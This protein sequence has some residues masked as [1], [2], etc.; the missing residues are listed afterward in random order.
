MSYENPLRIEPCLVDPLPSAL[1]DLVAEVG[2]AAAALG[3]ALHPRT[4]RS[5]S[6]LVALMNCYYSNLIEG[7]RTRPRDI[8]RALV[9]E[10]DTDP[11]RRDLQLEAISHVRVQSAIESDFL[12]GRMADPTSPP[13]ILKLHQDFYEGAS[14]PMLQLKRADGSTFQMQPG[15]FRKLASED[16]V[17]GLHQPPTSAFVDSFMSHFHE[18]YRFDKLGGGMRIVAIAAAHH[19]FNFIHPFSDGNGRVSRLMSHA[20]SLAAGIGAHGL[21][22]ISRGLA[23]GLADRSDYHRMMNHADSP[24]QSAVDGRGNLSEKAL[25]EFVAWFLEVAL[26][27]IRFMQSLFDLG[28]LDQRIQSYVVNQLHLSEECA[29]GVSAIATR[30]TMPRGQ[31]TRQLANSERRGREILSE[32]VSQKLLRSETPKGDVYLNF[33]I[34]SSEYLFP[35]LF[36]VGE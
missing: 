20:M 33:S 27:Q 31:A 4:A 34:A 6:Q 13:F 21:W 15:R 26:D 22:S 11:V 23:R 29:R 14:E 2:K 1:V 17:V 3:A 5:L 24:R 16:N 8:E 36:P 25:V 18:R 12:E 30:G 9:N 32:L 7:H 10:L 35:Q 28:A 19:R